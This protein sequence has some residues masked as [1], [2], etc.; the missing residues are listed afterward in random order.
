[1]NKAQLVQIALG[2]ITTH[3]MSAE[4]TAKNNLLRAREN[5]D[6]LEIDKTLRKTKLDLSK[7]AD[8]K[9]IAK[10]RAEIKNLEQQQGKIL[11]KLNIQPA[12]LIPRY[13]CPHCKDSGYIDGIACQCLNRRVQHALIKQSGMGTRLQFSFDTCDSRI[14][15]ENANLKKAYAL[16]KKYID[17]FPSP[18]YPNLVFMGDVGSGK[19]YLAECIAN[20]L[21]KRGHYVVF[22]N[23]FDL[24]QTVQYSFGLSYSEREA[25]LAPY[26]ESELLIIDD[27]GSEPIIRNI[28]L[29]NLFVVINSRQS[30]SLPTIISTNLNLDELQDRY[31]DRIISRIFN[32]RTTITIP[33][34]GKDLR[35]NN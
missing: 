10:L 26:F 25:L 8:E 19:T 22:S 12:E 14:V 6:F 5:A 13:A 34:V 16:A 35:L 27:L 33:F 29:A 2:E 31:G 30:M 20:S 9:E 11:K 3:K 7:T 4:L 28:T 23:A 21:L 24:N 1:M 32:K 17:S 18:K 15:S